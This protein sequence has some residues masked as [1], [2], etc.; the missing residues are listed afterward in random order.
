MT[1]PLSSSHLDAKCARAQPWV[2]QST[3]D[4]ADGRPWGYAIFYDPVVESDKMENAMCRMDLLLQNAQSAVS[5][6][7]SAI[8]L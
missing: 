1:Q 4:Y 7:V 8:P 3:Q 5:W 2:H 6:D